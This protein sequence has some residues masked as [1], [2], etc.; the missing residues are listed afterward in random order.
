MKP[1]EFVD[2]IRKSGIV[3]DE[4]RRIYIAGLLNEILKKHGTKVTLVG[5]AIVAFFTAGHYTT[6]DIDIVAKKPEKVKKV[7]RELGFKDTGRGNRFVHADL[8]V[9]VEYMGE[10]PKAERFDA[11]KIRDVEL[12][13]IS[14]EDVL[15]SKLKMLDK[16]VDEGKSNAQVKVIAYLLEKRLDEKYLMD[17]LVKENLW[18]LWT[19]IKAEVDEYGPER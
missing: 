8:G 11:V 1:E 12:D 19:R 17:R 3:K 6:A 14:V 5:G 7:L 16:G 18:E 15:I 10:L 4:E 13:I 2:R 9:I